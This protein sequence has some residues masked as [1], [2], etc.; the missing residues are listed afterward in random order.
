MI[1]V[2]AA[3]LM[4]AAAVAQQGEKQP[5]PEEMQKMMAEYM[6]MGEPGPEHAKL[7]T[8]AG[9]WVTQTKMWMSPDAEP[10]DTPAGTRKGEMILGGR[11]LRFAETGDMMGM[12]MEGMGI[13]GYDNFRRV[14]QMIWIDNTATPIYFASGTA[15]VTGKVITLMGKADDPIKGEKNKDTKWVCRFE[16]ETKI[17]FE[18]W[19]SIGEGKFYK[20][21]ETVYTKK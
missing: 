19:D 5:S 7:A 6:K 13:M 3:V 20:S 17:V 1:A 16:S 4:V 2:C 9:E 11:F 12:P 21:F 15:D 8:W 14:Y 10:M 18:I